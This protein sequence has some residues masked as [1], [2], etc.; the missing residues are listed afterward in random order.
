MST[1]SSNLTPKFYTRG[2]ELNMIVK[3]SRKL[4]SGILGMPLN[5]R[6]FKWQR[7]STRRKENSCKNSTR[8][9]RMSDFEKLTN[10]GIKNKRTKPGGHLVSE[11]KK[12]L[13]LRWPLWPGGLRWRWRFREG[14][15]SWG[16]LQAMR[17]TSRSSARATSQCVA[18]GNGQVFTLVVR[19][20]DV[21]LQ[22]P[23]SGFDL[24]WK[25]VHEDYVEFSWSPAGLLRLVVLH[26]A[27]SRDLRARRTLRK[28]EGDA[29]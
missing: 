4:Q 19:I 6:H 21:D 2:T 8:G 20:I 1:K 29:N 24:T 27:S 5:A 26:T 15:G 22:P 28:D 18:I 7:R 9:K 23:G 16:R 13:L 11:L 25:L 12:I 17:A 14:C 10:A 3:G